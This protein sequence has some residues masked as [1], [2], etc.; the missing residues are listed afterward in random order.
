MAHAAPEHVVVI[1]IVVV[2]VLFSPGWFA[3]LGLGCGELNP[4]ASAFPQR[5]VQAR[6]SRLGVV[7]A[8]HVHERELF[9]YVALDYFAEFLE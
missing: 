7:V 1:H 4:E 2:L 6:Y 9:E 3:F 8:L 5:V